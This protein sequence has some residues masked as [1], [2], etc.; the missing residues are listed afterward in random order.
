MP[1][2]PKEF[3]KSINQELILLKDRVKNLIEIDGVNHHGED[4]N[5][6]EVVLRNIIRKRLP[7]NISIGTGFVLNKID[8]AIKRTTQIDILIYDNS[9]PLLFKEGD[10][11]IT[12][13]QSVKAIIEVK[14]TI[15]NSDLNEILEK[16][17]DNYNL[18]TKNGGEIFNGVFSY[19]YKYNNLFDKRNKRNKKLTPTIKNS[20]KNTNGK[21]NH[22]SLGQNI[23]IKYWDKEYIDSITDDEIKNTIR[24]NCST[25]FFNIYQ[26]ENLSFA[27]FISN[28]IYWV[29]DK[30]I[31]EQSWFMFPIDSPNGKEN[32][33]ISQCCIPCEDT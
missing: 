6:R 21:V 20:L 30:D 2:N 28:L 12:T 9:Y 13:P 11:I 19:N 17:K 26:L 29:T 15:V 1:F 7:N 4:G 22:I 25:D 27:Y 24:Q 23:F 8:G 32:S 18:I 14:T 33:R 3:Q 10:F 16:S 31:D 5:Y